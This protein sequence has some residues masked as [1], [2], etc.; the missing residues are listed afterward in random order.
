MMSVKSNLLQHPN[1]CYV[2]F[3]LIF[4][5]FLKE[6]FCLYCVV[7]LVVMMS[8]KS[9]LLQHPNECYICINLLVFIVQ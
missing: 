5:L 2:L 1:K 3:S 6:I 7:N 8:V 9:N 4:H